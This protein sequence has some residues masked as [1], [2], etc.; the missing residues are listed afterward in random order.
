MT[1]GIG[2]EKCWWYYIPSG[3]MPREQEISKGTGDAGL[4]F[5]ARRR[6]R[7]QVNM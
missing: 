6:N 4:Q 7:E 2:R 1:A 3:H 5:K